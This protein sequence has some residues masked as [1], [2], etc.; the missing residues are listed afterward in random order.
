[1]QVLERTP[2]K[3][4]PTSEVEGVKLGPYRMPVFKGVRAEIQL[5]NLAI[6]DARFGEMIG[7]ALGQDP[8]EPATTKPLAAAK[9]IEPDDHSRAD[10]LLRR[11]HQLPKIDPRALREDVRDFFG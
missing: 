5:W 4:G 1:M 2:A 6:L 7:K 8:W 3:R 10:Q 11:W 9:R